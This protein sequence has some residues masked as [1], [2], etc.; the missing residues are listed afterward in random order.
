MSYIRVIPRDLFNEANLLKCYGQLYLLTEGLSH[1]ELVQD[2]A[3][4]PE[5]RIEQDIDGGLYITNVELHVNDEVV[6]LIRPLN[7]RQPH[8]LL[9]MYKGMWHSVCNTLG[10]LSN[11]FKELIRKD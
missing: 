6:D 8:A 11:E 7:S 9:F 10:E 4:P 5:F 2:D 1:V 3:G